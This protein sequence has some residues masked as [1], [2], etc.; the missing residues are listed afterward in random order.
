MGTERSSKGIKIL[1]LGNFLFGLGFG[2]YAYIFPNFVQSMKAT[3]PEVGLVMSLLYALQ[4]A[5]YIPGGILSDSGRR[6]KLVIASWVL[7]GL[8]PLSYILAE[9]NNSWPLVLPGVVIFASGWI[10]VPATYAYISEASPKGKRG[11][12]FGLL[13][14]YA[15]IGFIPSPLIGGLILEQYG[16]ATLF[17]VAFIVLTAGTL[18]VLP[19]PRLTMDLA[20]HNKT[21]SNNQNPHSKRNAGDVADGNLAEKRKTSSGSRGREH[22]SYRQLV[23]ILAYSCLFYGLVFIAYPFISIY[24]RDQYHFDY[25]TI[26]AMFSIVNISALIVGPMLGKISDKYT[27]ATKVALTAIPVLAYGLGYVV[28]VSTSSVYILPVT[29]V[30]MGSSAAFFVLIYSI[31]ADMSSR[32]KWG[33]VYGVLGG[34][35][36]AAQAATPFIGGILYSSWNQLPFIVAA[37]LMPLVLTLIYVA[38][39]MTKRCYG[40]R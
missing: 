6:R 24:L 39:R 19:L 20:A 17:L 40:M 30:L 26:Q 4:A 29:F 14:S 31:V 23:P 12:T 13:I 35:I 22:S 7:P 27:S 38:G 10:G 16:F 37:T 21:A 32:K 25:F 8:A 28:L 5:T 18:I 1:G 3:P 36:V 34:S 2:M 9:V 11:L 15:N 33:R